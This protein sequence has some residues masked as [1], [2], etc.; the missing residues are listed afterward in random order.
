MFF[1]LGHGVVELHGVGLVMTEDLLH[2]M[3]L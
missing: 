3:H 1:F 2:Y